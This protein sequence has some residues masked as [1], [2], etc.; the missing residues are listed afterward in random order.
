M[1][2]ETEAKPTPTTPTEGGHATPEPKKAPATNVDAG[3]KPD[4]TPEVK[5]PKQSLVSQRAKAATPPKAKGAPAE[6]AGDDTE[7]VDDD[8]TASEQEPEGAPEG[9]PEKYEFQAPEGQEFDGPTLSACEEAFREAGLNNEKAQKILDKVA[10]V[11]AQR[12]QQTIE[13]QQE[14][15]LDE[16]RKDPV[17]GG[18]H[19]EANIGLAEKGYSMLPAPAQKLFDGPLGD[20]P[21]M[22]AL[23]VWLG[24]RVSPDTQAGRG[25]AAEKAAE[26]TEDDVLAAQ[27]P[28]DVVQ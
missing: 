10:P 6:A 13:A 27:Y 1:T 25:A 7:V 2:T 11:M 26:I 24:K 22:F 18:A 14:A 9:P 3:K 12:Q 20:H 23:Q 8:Q 17:L 5:Q 28:N 15:W 19:L 16:I 4:A 21:A